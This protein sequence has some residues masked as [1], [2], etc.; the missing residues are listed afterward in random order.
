MKASPK[1]GD[2]GELRFTVER[3]HAVDFSSEG[4]PLVLSTPSL[5]WFLEHA[6]REVLVPLQE[7]GES[8]VG[9]EIELQHLAPTPLGHAVRCVARVTNVEGSRVSFQLEAHDERELIAK[10][11]HRRFVVRAERFT[12]T[13]QGKAKG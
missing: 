13:V 12:H 7:P 2:I 11:F 5:L 3:Q 1:V 10:G 4:M 8:S 6:A 9:T